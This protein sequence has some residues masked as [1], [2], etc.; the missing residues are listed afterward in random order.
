ML[1]LCNPTSLSLVPNTYKLFNEY[2]NI[3]DYDALQFIILG[4]K[5][6]NKNAYIEF[7]KKELDDKN[8]SINIIPSSAPLA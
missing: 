8:S 1:D 6:E 2:L 4:S 3:F 7:L 5:I